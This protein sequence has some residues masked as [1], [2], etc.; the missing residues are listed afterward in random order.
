MDKKLE[1]R[2]VTCQLVADVYFRSGSPPLMAQQPPPPTP[3]QEGFVPFD[4]R[5]AQEQ[6][7]AAPLVMVAYA[8]AWVV[9]FAHR[10]VDLA[11]SGS[12][13]A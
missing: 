2:R 9:V 3:A 10:L 8:V 1:A 5:Q 13:G 6:L 12:G 11:A 7:P 4:Q